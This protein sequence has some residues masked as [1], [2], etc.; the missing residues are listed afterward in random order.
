MNEYMRTKQ[1]I[2]LLIHALTLSVCVWGGGGGGELIRL[3]HFNQADNLY[4][5]YVI[6]ILSKVNPGVLKYAESNDTIVYTYMKNYAKCQLI[7]TPL[8]N[9]ITRSH[10][11]IKK[12]YMFKYQFRNESLT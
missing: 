9:F 1:R 11:N 6:F 10:C 7:W 3:L 8:L 5:L 4:P 2:W 12:A